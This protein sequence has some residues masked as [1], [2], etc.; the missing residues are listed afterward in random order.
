MR[1]GDKVWGYEW[2]D[3]Y[4]SIPLRA[5]MEWIGDSS[6]LPFIQAQKEGREREKVE[7]ENQDEVES[8][9]SW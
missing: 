2:M 6:L 9:K 1:E 3:V 4:T 5:F 8:E 7:V